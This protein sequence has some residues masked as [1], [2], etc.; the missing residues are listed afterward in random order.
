MIAVASGDGGYAGSV[1]CPGTQYPAA[2]PYVTAVGGTVLSSGGPGNWSE[3]TWPSSGSGCSVYESKPNWQSDPGCLNRTVADVAAVATNVSIC[4]TYKTGGRWGLGAGTSVAAPITA[5]VYAL[6]GQEQRLSGASYSYGHAAE[7][8]DITS[9]SNGSCGGSY[10]CTAGVGYDGPTGN[11]SPL[12]AA[13]FGQDFKWAGIVDN[14]SNGAQALSADGSTVFITGIDVSNGPQNDHVTTAFDAASGSELW[15]QH[16]DDPW[17]YAAGAAAITVSPDSSEVFVTGFSDSKTG[18][19]YPNITTVAYDAHTG[20]QLWSARFSRPGEGVFVAV[21][22]DGSRVFVTGLSCILPTC[23]NQFTT[24]A[25]DPLSGAQLWLK[26]YGGNGFQ[27]IPYLVT[28]SPDSTRVFVTGSH[29]DLANYVGA[30][31]AYDAGTG[32][33]LWARGYKQ[34]VGET[35]AVSPDGTKLFV[36]GSGSPYPTVIA[37]D[38]ATGKQLWAKPYSSSAYSDAV[39]IVVN[40]SGAAVYVT[41]KAPSPT[42]IVQVTTVAFDTSTGRRLWRSE[43]GVNAYTGAGGTPTPIITSGDGSLVYVLGSASPD[44]AS[45]PDYVTLTY[46]AGSGQQDAVRLYAGPPDDGC[47]GTS[48]ARSPDDSRLFSA[49]FC[50]GI[51]GPSFIATVAYGIP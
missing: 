16:Y 27:S 2:S 30:T 7:L 43:Y 35:L 33:Q 46:E 19:G 10:L 4:D 47:F 31:V 42:G 11:G 51:S 48:I 45:S 44:Q 40:P 25:Y 5:G 20:A 14:A 18:F 6:A 15:V 36:T 41:G 32:S 49:G 13:G 9:G 39:G 50:N 21:S 26:T 1:D 29:Q 8:T 3:T 34:E 23:W 38:A 24:I 37:H 17:G 28:V 12:G 22:P